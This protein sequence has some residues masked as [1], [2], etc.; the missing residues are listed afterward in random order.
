MITLNAILISL[1]GGVS[2]I[3]GTVLWIALLLVRRLRGS[4]ATLRLHDLRCVWGLSAFL[5]IPVLF[6]WMP[7]FIAETGETILPYLYGLAIVLLAASASILIGTVVSAS[8]VTLARRTGLLTNDRV[9]P[10]KGGWQLRLVWLASVFVGVPLLWSRT[11]AI[12]QKLALGFGG[13]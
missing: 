7:R 2:A 4:P 6:P 9:D 8:T 1:T 11:S 10:R 5:G 3:V 12:V 13:G